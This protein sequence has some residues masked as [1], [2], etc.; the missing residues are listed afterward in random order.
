[1]RFFQNNR[2][3]KSTEEIISMFLGLVIVVVVIGL[4]FT[5]F[6]KRKGDITLPGINNYLDISKDSE[7]K[8]NIDNSTEEK[9]T[10][11]NEVYTVVKGDS[12][13]KIAEKKYNNGFM[14]N[15]IV[16]VNDLKNPRLLSVGQKLVMPA[17]AAEG[18]GDQKAIINNQ[19]K[20]DT[21][22]DYVVVKNDNLW[23]IAVRAYGDGYQWTKIWDNNKN[24]IKDPGV[25][26]VGTKLLIP[27]LNN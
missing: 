4:V 7:N 23:N 26:K 19:A 10:S 1:M 8:T 25:I 14:W 5:Y 17:I 21:G 9:I 27:K 22:S 13:W 16:K 2:L 6:Q 15:E 20:I 24:A 11:Q 18:K 3:F 12:L